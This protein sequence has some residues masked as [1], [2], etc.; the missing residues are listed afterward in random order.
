MNPPDPLRVLFY[1]DSPVVGGA[2]NVA[3]SLVAS[4]GP[5]IQPVI[6]GVDPAVVAHIASGR[7][8]VAT[9]VLDRVAGRADLRTVAAHASAFWE[10]NVDVVHVDR[11][12]WSGQYGLL[13]ATWAG[14]P[15]LSVVHGV[16]PASSASQRALTVAT[17]RL[18]PRY[19]GVSEH[20]SRQVH[21]QLCI[22]SERVTTV[23]N[24][25]APHPPAGLGRS[26]G[27]APEP[28]AVLCVG[29]L[30]REKGVDLLVRAMAGVPSADAVVL[31]DGAERQQL[32]ALAWR[33]GVTGR[34][35]FEGWVEG[36]T[37]RYSPQVVVVPSRF[38]ALSVVALEA[39]R[40][41]IPVV[42]TRV[43]GI[44]EVVVDS[45]TGLLVAPDDPAALGAAIGSL[46]ADG[47]RREAMGAAGRERVALRFCLDTMVA[48]YEALYSGLAQRPTPARRVRGLAHALPPELRRRAFHAARA[49][50]AA[51]AA[52]AR[53]SPCPTLADQV[54]AAHPGA[55]RG[56]VLLVGAEL[57]VGP[58]PWVERWARW[59]RNVRRLDA[60]VVADLSHPGALGRA[61]YDGVLAVDSAW[62]PADR[63][64]VL[65]NL[66]DAL[67]PGGTLLVV[68]APDPGQA[69]SDEDLLDALPRGRRAPL[70][71]ARALLGNGRLATRVD[72]PRHL[73]RT[74]RTAVALEVRP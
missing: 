52:R 51:G 22:P 46:L 63:K 40:A 36:W 71:A 26:G 68:S 72:K 35:R 2:E 42:A 59:D 34:V 39:M 43:G 17:A 31:G 25:L 67:R 27:P 66:W 10:L 50:S 62:P 20:V 28:V 23:Y 61:A 4:L 33:L 5:H 41:G 48:A 13:A 15:A 1:T 60:S 21:R 9:R 55:L 38:E 30:A 11:H 53:P 19:V 45:V 37:A 8:G 57:P 7:E 29:R 16:L 69:W 24:G 58:A 74:T 6:A 12:L 49:A 44:P 70:G 54:A 73:D 3:R 47:R 64:V 32:E 18:A 65:A 56:E 14:V